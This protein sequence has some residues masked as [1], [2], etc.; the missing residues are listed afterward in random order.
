[1]FTLA[2]LFLSQSVMA[3]VPA[4]VNASDALWDALRD[5]D[6]SGVI[7]FINAGVSPNAQTDIDTPL[8][9][10][11]KRDSIEM[12]T[13]L[14]DH[15]ANPN[16]AQPISQ[17]TPLMVAAKHQNVEATQLLLAHHA[18]VNFTGAFGRNPLHIAALHD[19]IEVAHL[20]LKTNIDVNTRGSLCPLA[21]ASRQGYLDFVT[22]L[23]TEAQVKPTEKCL[24]SA[25]DMATNNQH[26]DVL[27]L[28]NTVKI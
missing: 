17:F 18:N 8:T 14:L 11:I 27:A 22:A 20:L 23:L 7:G 21:V 10:A 28:L 6:V 26:A 15:G 24:S 1:M 4:P 5:D 12:V 2:F 9:Y 16:T 3:Q 25:K 13:A 19:S